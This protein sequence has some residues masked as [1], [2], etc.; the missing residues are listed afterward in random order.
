MHIAL[1]AGSVALALV[2]GATAVGA[3]DT[4][5][6]PAFP[7][8]SVAGRLQFQGYWFDNADY[9]P[10]AAGNVGTESSFFI[11]RAR[12]Q[13]DGRI[14]ERVSFVIQPSFENGAGREPNLRLRDAYIDLE[15]TGE[16]A[17]SS[18]TLRVGQE[19]R[20]F[21]RWELTSSN[22]LPVIERGA[23][24]GLLGRASNNVF[25]RNGFLSH[26][27]GA[28]VLVRGGRATLQAGVYNGQGESFNDVNSSKSYG[29]RAT[30]AP[31]AG[32]SV[33]A[34]WFS[35]DAILVPAVGAPDS[36]ARN[37]AWEIDAQWGRPGAPGLFLLGEYLQGEDATEAMAPIR[38]LAAIA[39]W[40][41]RLAPSRAP[42]QLW[43]IEPALRI[44][45]ADPDADADDDRATLASAVLGLY[46]SSRAQLRVG[47]ERQSFEDD[48][49]EAIQGLRTAVTVSF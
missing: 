30:V 46:F 40:H 1:R 12:I 36:S 17:P 4:T 24:R 41:R 8:V 29:V 37:D 31:V 23:G 19:K 22:N 44:D 6:A 21:S 2:A 27:L 48:A 3:Q 7:D 14:A 38:G 39:A 15:L 43:A 5:S 20:P 32:L 10:A 45:V 34:S 35:H 16:A 33:G 49:L 42:L 18:V 13:V 28:S 26:D 47:Y 9:A 25:E 11:R